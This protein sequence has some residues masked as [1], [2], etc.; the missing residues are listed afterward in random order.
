MTSTAQKIIVLGATGATGKEALAAALASSATSAVF[1]FGRRSP[2]V[3]NLQGAEKLQHS[4]LDFDKLL[5]GK[6]NA[7]YEAEA[8]KLRDVDVSLSLYRA[9]ILS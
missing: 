1:S 5:L 6:G 8:K 9:L 2:P 4:T 3:D 7:E